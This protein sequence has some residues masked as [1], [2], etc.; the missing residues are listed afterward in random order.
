MIWR[1]IVF[2]VILALIWY[3][4]PFLGLGEP[5][6]TVLRALVILG[7]IWALLGAAGIAPGPWGKTPSA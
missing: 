1:A 6:T 3:V 4:L 5:F 7:V 2:I